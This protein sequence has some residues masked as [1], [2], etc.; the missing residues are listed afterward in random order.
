M[1]QTWFLTARINQPFENPQIFS[2]WSVIASLEMR[3]CSINRGYPSTDLFK[4]CNA[5]RI[6]RGLQTV[7]HNK[8]AQASFLTR[9]ECQD[10]PS[11]LFCDLCWIGRSALGQAHSQ[12]GPPWQRSHKAGMKIPQPYLTVV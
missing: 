8:A 7:L 5:G 9:A 12:G 10:D 6:H 1:N 2:L 4:L 11:Q 3:V